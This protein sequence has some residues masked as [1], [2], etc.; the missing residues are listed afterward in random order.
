[1]S[2]RERIRAKKL[3]ERSRLNATIR[4]FFAA[5]NFIEIDAPIIVS[6]PGLELHLDAFAVAND[7]AARY[8][9]TSPEYQMKRLLA[10]GLNRIYSLGKV[11]RRKEAGPQHNPEFTMLEWYRAH[12]GWQAIAG[13]V[14]ELVKA[15]ARELAV[16]RMGECVL[17]GA[18]EQ[19]SVGDACEKFGGVRIDGDEDVAALR[20]KI[21]ARGHR[22]PADGD[23]SDLFFTFFLDHVER[24]LGK[25]RPTI[26]FDWPRPLC[27]LAREKPGDARVVERFEAYAAGLELCNAFGELTDPVEQR[28]RMEQ[29]LDERRRRE[30]AQYPIDE[31]FLAALADMPPSAGVALGVDRLAMLLLGA[32]DIREVIAFADDE[33]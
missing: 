17:G 8:L 11:F 28:R 6:S 19:L 14:E 1:M 3:A 10:G 22:L 12:E 18:W 13:D 32:R 7:E 16:S 29:D 33:L 2:E 25:A 15:C 30:L 23:W 27:A 21:A 20:H 31:K 5:R 9:I 24:E 4:A 26:L